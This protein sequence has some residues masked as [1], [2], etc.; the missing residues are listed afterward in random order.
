MARKCA[1]LACADKFI[2]ALL[3]GYDTNIGERGTALSGGQRQR[4]AL[5]RLFLSSAPILIL[6]EATSALDSETEQQ[7][8]RNLQKVRRNR[9]V[10][11]IAHRFA[12]LKQADLILVLEKGVLVEQ[13]KHDEL[14]SQGGVYWSLYQGQQS[15]VEAT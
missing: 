13:G 7:V 9:T 10:F 2:T 11:A 4:L 14:L 5:A 8:L 15:S 12:P 6:D 1:R 3:D